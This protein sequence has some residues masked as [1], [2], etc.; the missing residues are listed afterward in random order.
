MMAA[1]KEKEEGTLGEMVY[2]QPNGAER[3]KKEK[4]EKEKSAQAAKDAVRHARLTKGIPF[5]DAQGKGY[6]KNGKKVYENSGQ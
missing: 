2:S 1:K 3:K 4:A 5:S 6:I